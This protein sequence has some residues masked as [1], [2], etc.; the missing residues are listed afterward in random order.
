MVDAP[1]ATAGAIGGDVTDAEI[2]AV[3][4]RRT[5]FVEGEFRA[6]GT[7]LNTGLMTVINQGGRLKAALVFD[8]GES[9][10]EGAPEAG[11]SSRTRS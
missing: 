7:L 2:E 9:K 3:A 6:L 5:V 8:L 10:P 4:R 1:T 11:P